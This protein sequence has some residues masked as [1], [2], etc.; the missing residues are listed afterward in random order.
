MSTKKK[1]K[2][3]SRKVNGRKKRNNI[4][5]PPNFYAMKKI[6]ERKHE[7]NITRNV[8]IKQQCHG[9]IYLVCLLS[10]YRRLSYMP[11]TI[12]ISFVCALVICCCW[13][14]IPT[15]QLKVNNQI[16]KPLIYR[17]HP[18]MVSALLS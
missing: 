15:K 12:F 16:A 17:S 18:F 6:K 5:V 10:P 3:A 8:C 7:T 2:F 4:I 11:H 1:K 13:C 14:S 9:R